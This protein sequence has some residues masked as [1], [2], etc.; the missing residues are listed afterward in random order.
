M[1]LERGRFFALR[2]VV[3]DRQEVG[4]DFNGKV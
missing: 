4:W 3:S 2:Q 1:R